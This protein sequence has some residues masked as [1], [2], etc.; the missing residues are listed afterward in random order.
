MDRLSESTPPIPG[1]ERGAILAGLGQACLLIAVAALPAWSNR[2]STFG[3]EPDKSWLLI[4]LTFAGLGA[5][6]AAGGIAYFRRNVSVPFRRMP[7]PAI[8]GLIV[9]LSFMLLST[10]LSIQPAWSWW[11]SPHR[12][13][14]LLTQLALLGVVWIIASSFRDTRS[15]RLLVRAIVLSSV[16]VVI[17]GLWQAAGW[18]LPTL[19]SGDHFAGRPFSTL[20]N[21]LFL[22]SY[23]I[24][25]IPFTA[26]EMVRGLKQRE[27]DN[28]RPLARAGAIT[29]LMISQLLVLL[30][31]LARGAWVGLAGGTLFA[32]FAFTLC[33]GPRRAA[34]GG[35]SLLLILLIGILLTSATQFD[36]QLGDTSFGQLLDPTGSGRQRLEIWNE[37][38]HYLAGDAVPITRLLVGHGLDTGGLILPNQLA[39]RAPR[40]DLTDDTPLLL[41]RS[42][43]IILDS[44]LTHGLFGLTAQVV[45]LITAIW[46]GLRQM[47]QRVPLR[48]LAAGGL[49]GMVSM[50]LFAWFLTND[51]SLLPVALGLGIGVGLV[52]ALLA[53]MLRPLSARQ[54]APPAENQILMLAALGA[55]FGYWI[56]LQFGFETQAASLLAWIALALLISRSGET[57]HT[58][59]RG[60]V[61]PVGV[62]HS[63]T[64]FTYYEMP[65]PNASPLLLASGAI[66]VACLLGAGLKA[67]GAT[68][69]PVGAIWLTCGILCGLWCGTRAISRYP[70]LSLGPMLFVLIAARLFERFLNGYA[71][72]PAVG[73][74]I[75]TW[76]G[77]LLCAGIAGWGVGRV[78][79][80]KIGGR[81]ILA[82]VAF[83]GIALFGIALV[84]RPAA[85]DILTHQGSLAA[86]GGEVNDAITLLETAVIWGPH[87]T[88]PYDMLSQI[89]L[90]RA[91]TAQT[92]PIMEDA[93]S[94]AAGAMDAAWH[95]SP[96]QAEFGRRLAWVYREWA[97]QTIA[98]DQRLVLLRK[99]TEALE[100]AASIAPADQRIRDDLEHTR[101]LL[102]EG[103]AS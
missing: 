57:G 67:G 8:I 71:G 19:W 31:S 97:N 36:I 74:T 50:G 98:P 29:L 10:A 25:A 23:L 63:N 7:A 65:S 43:N 48:A 89:W 45:L 30:S 58:S 72:W 37:L 69:I 44:L 85:G 86:R 2:Y 18:P 75:I 14:G 16:P 53:N 32:I 59:R 24:L 12:A 62:K 55:L 56:D 88:P 52:I 83:I 95:A 101:Q 13:W 102:T 28:Y 84:I 91:R 5:T 6:I 100:L 87:D 99:A 35:A 22:G 80:R 76:I 47:G 78:T 68:L 90:L 92:A 66:L 51:F 70:L 79:V 49:A 61:Q 27:R 26:T 82:G 3:F 17:I 20:G 77:V 39:Y 4:L 11:G 33:R 1:R 42:H 34:V 96:Y 38:V 41:D 46:A 15:R 93:Y 54:A 64:A 103:E 81:Q 21:P 60:S 9:V 73:T 40:G 94:H